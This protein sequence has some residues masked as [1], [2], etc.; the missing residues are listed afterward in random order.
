MTTYSIDTTHSEITFTVRHMVFA[1]VRGQFNSWAAGLTFDAADRSRSKVHVE[2]D[3]ASI[4]TREPKRD[5][6]LRSGDFLAVSE[7]PK[8]VFDSTK[9]EAAGA[10]HYKLTGNLTLRGATHEVTLDVEETGQ[11]KDPWGN[12]RLGFRATGKIERSRWGVVWN[13]PLE[14]GGVL[15]SDTIDLEV[16]V[17]VVATAGLREG[18][19]RAARCVDAPGGLTRKHSVTMGTRGAGVPSLADSSPASSKAPASDTG[20]EP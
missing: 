9:I 11:G 3:V 6:H 18:S 10:G 8:M 12:Q 15:V 4:D 19:G 13:A 7:H 16:E 5:E 17:Q 1:K 14:T 2:V 20:I